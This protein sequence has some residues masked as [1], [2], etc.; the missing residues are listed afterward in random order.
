M[1]GVNLL[2]WLDLHYWFDSYPGPLAGVFLLAVYGLILTFLLAG[3]AL[4]VIRRF[5]I[6]DT[7]IRQVARRLNTLTLTLGILLGL[8]LFFSQS[9][10]PVLGSRFWFLL[11]LV[12]GAAWLVKFIY[13]LLKIVPQQRRWRLEKQKQAKYL[14][15]TK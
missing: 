6:K 15:A 2:T 10:T 1:S 5:F 11:W 4:F 12:G 3:A 7:I 14:S 8:F 13:Y 9:Q